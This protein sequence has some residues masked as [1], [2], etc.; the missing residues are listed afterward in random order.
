MTEGAE[1]FDFPDC[2]LSVLRDGSLF[3]GEGDRRFL[4]SRPPKISGPPLGKFFSKNF[5][6]L[7]FVRNVQKNGFSV[8]LKIAAAKKC[9]PSATCLK[10]FGPAP[11]PISNGLC[12]PL[13][14]RFL[15]CCYNVCLAFLHVNLRCIYI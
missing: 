4:F 13:H 2:H 3:M 6:S 8:F 11:S 12:G 14:F 1:E 9:T 7:I 10:I 15:T 5:F